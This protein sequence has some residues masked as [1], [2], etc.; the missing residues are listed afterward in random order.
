MAAIAGM[1]QVF[2]NAGTSGSGQRERY[3]ASAKPWR[4]WSS[5]DADDRA[6]QNE[7]AIAQLPT[8]V[9]QKIAPKNAE[10]KRDSEAILVTRAPAPAVCLVPLL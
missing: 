3:R 8:R 5:P 6:N 1:P 7:P 10:G 2:K 4:G 9:R